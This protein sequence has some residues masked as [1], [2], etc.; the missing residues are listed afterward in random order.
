MILLTLILS[1]SR[2]GIA[3]VWKDIGENFIRRRAGFGF[4]FGHGMGAISVYLAEDKWFLQMRI[5]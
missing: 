1:I 5:F 3:D 4:S 2:Q